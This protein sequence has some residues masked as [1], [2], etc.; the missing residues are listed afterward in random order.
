VKGNESW[1]LPEISH[2]TLVIVTWQYLPLDRGKQ[3][4]FIDPN[5]RAPKC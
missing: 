2:M 4:M 3:G 1:T 5:L